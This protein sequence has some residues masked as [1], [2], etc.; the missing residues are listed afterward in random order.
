MKKELIGLSVEAL[1][2]EMESLGEKSFRAK[3][4]W[5][6]IYNKGETDFFSMTTLSKSFQ[7]KLNELY[8]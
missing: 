4:L 6:W 3:Q 1:K 7:A 8:P 2:E 5:H